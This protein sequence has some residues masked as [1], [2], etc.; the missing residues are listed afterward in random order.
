MKKGF[1]IILF[2]LVRSTIL[3]ASDPKF[4]ATVNKTQVGVGEQFEVDFTIYGSGSHFTAPDFSAFQFISGPNVAVGEENGTSKITYGYVLQATKEG[5]FNI[6]AAAIVVNGHTLLTNQLKIKVQGHAPPQQ[7]QQTQVPKSTPHQD[8]ND[9]EGA[10]D[11]SKSVFIKAEVNK[12]NVY[13]GQQI[14]V[15]YKLYT[16]MDIAGGQP[17]KAPDLNGFWSQDII[18]KNQKA[19]NWTSETYKG[20]RYSVVVIKQT[21]IFPQHP[22]DLTID[23]LAMT[24]IVRKRN[25]KRVFNN[26][27]G[28][29]EDVKYQ[30][31]SAPVT[32]HAMPL[33]TEGKPADFSGAVGN[34]SVYTDVDK[35]ELKANETINYTFE[36]R[37]SGNL[38]LINPPRI[39]PPADFE[40]YDPKTTDRITTDSTG[41]SGSRQFNYLLIPRHQGDYTLDLARFSYFDPIVKR[42]V[43]VPTNTFNIKVVKGDVQVNVPVFN[44]ADQQDIKMLGNDIRYIKTA[45]VAL[46][47]D[48]IEFYGTSWY[49][50]LLLLGPLGFASAIVYRRWW[51]NYNSDIVLVKSRKAAKVA[52]QRLAAAGK[53]LAAGNKDAF[54]EE[55]AK[56]LYGYLSDKLSIPVADLNRENIAE[57][58]NTRSVGQPVIAELNDTLDRCEMA[59]FAPVA[60]LSQQQ[61]FEK[62]KNV[63]HEIEK[64]L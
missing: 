46:H 59:R 61:I 41:E 18:N 52:S 57:R 21:A 11:P 10:N 32:I 64:E 56:G 53:E 28:N 45:A 9:S 36:V 4:V 24:F 13:T 1:Y 40:K 48:E 20:L 60:S 47:K 37:G 55:L 23:P 35:K 2:L 58:L 51:T 38:N 7:V 31:K 63:I 14:I 33:P 5:T 50:I 17:D 39:T 43:T 22:G 30:T 44:S 12:T 16:R 15:R 42:Y 8:D 34:Y 3:F 25:E 19:A 26:A 49:C 62:A 54:F 6:T 29:Y 27:F